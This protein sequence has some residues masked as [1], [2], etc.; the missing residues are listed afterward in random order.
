MF[1][2]SR[3]AVKEVNGIVI[4]REACGIPRSQHEARGIRDSNEASFMLVAVGNHALAHRRQ[5]CLNSLRIVCFWLTLAS[6]RLC[7]R[8]GRRILKS[9]NLL[10]QKPS[11]AP[12]LSLL[13]NFSFRL[14]MDSRLE[15]LRYQIAPENILSVGMAC[16]LWSMVSADRP[17]QR[18]GTAAACTRLQSSMIAGP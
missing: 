4:H 7:S 2:C 8:V 5:C 17:A 11:K 10:R 9:T 6:S 1:R 13:F 16:G 14:Q 18:S 3:Q 12:N 15:T